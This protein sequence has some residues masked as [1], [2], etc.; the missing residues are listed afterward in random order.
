MRLAKVRKGSELVKIDIK[1]FAKPTQ[2]TVPKT[3]GVGTPKL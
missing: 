2:C 1:L 3:N